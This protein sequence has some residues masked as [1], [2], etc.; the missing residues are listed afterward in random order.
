MYSMVEVK[1]TVSNLDYGETL[2]VNYELNNDSAV[3]RY[4][5]MNIK[6]KCYILIFKTATLATN[7]KMLNLLIQ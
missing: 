2:M 1:T 3:Y 6:Y 7:S 5:H 4:V